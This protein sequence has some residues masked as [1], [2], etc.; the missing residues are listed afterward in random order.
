MWSMSD[1]SMKNESKNTEVIQMTMTMVT[2]PVALKT[3]TALPEPSLVLHKLDPKLKLYDVVYKCKKCDKFFGTANLLKFHYRKFHTYRKFG[4]HLCELRFHH[5][6]SLIVHVDLK[7]AS[8]NGDIRKHQ[9]NKCSLSF[10]KRQNLYQHYKS[11]HISRKRLGKRLDISRED[12]SGKIVCKVCDKVFNMRSSLL[13]HFDLYHQEGEERRHKCQSCD[14]SFNIL[15]NYLRHLKSHIVADDNST[16]Y[17]CIHCSKAFSSVRNLQTHSRQE[18]LMKSSQLKTAAKRQRKRPRFKQL[19]PTGSK[20]YGHSSK[21]SCDPCGQVFKTR[22][23]YVRHV[24][25]N[26]EP[27]NGVPRRYLCDQCPRSFNIHQNLDS[28]LSSQHQAANT[29]QCDE[30]N[31]KFSTKVTLLFHKDYTHSTENDVVKR[32]MCEQCPKS[33]RFANNLNR[34]VA[35]SHLQKNFKCKLCDEAFSFKWRLKR[36]ED[37][38]HNDGDVA[39]KKY[40]CDKCS[41][42]F[43]LINSLRRHKKFEH[44]K[45][46]NISKIKEENT[47]PCEHCAQSFKFKTP[48]LTHMRKEHPQ[49]RKHAKF[50]KRAKSIE[51]ERDETGAYPCKLCGTDSICLSSYRLHKDYFH[52]HDEGNI[53]KYQCG[54]CSMSFQLRANIT[55]HVQSHCSSQLKR[56]KKEKSTR[57]KQRSKREERFSCKYCGLDFF[58]QQGL[59]M[60]EDVSHEPFSNEVRRFKCSLCPRSF[61]YR[62]NIKRH[63]QKCLLEESNSNFAKKDETM[64]RRSIRTLMKTESEWKDDF[65]L[66]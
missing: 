1:A 48:F 5:R 42:G 2:V 65:D 29:I 66:E 38:E 28:H 34:H 45:I 23:A 13:P 51:M 16:N 18:H 24:D 22:K 58:T 27:Q 32:N 9:C 36:H 33:Y 26:H 4:C 49:P 35:A 60:H 62:P 43:M 10:N 6:T 31:G 3:D 57:T 55:R 54:Q 44:S 40:L 56:V 64:T 20:H 17:F 39:S 8:E 12:S 30:C 47:F 52:G 46:P 14:R 37:F 59:R 7:H 19:R 15:A 63:L 41:M 25:K 53:R 21:L 50:P 61:N 11:E